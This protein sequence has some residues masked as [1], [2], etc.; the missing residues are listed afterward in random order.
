MRARRKAIDPF[1]HRRTIGLTAAVNGDGF[2][3]DGSYQYGQIISGKLCYDR[4]FENTLKSI[5]NGTGRF[6]FSSKVE[7]S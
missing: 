6:K 1:E 3:V 4:N 7:P 5:A 2:R